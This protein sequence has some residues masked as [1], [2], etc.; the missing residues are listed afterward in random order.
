[1]N[2]AKSQEPLASLK[3]QQGLSKQVTLAKDK[4]YI[5]FTTF[6]AKQTSSEPVAKSQ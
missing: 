1:M 5:M 3:R 6:S 2:K 4:Y